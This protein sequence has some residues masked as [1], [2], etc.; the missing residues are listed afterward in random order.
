MKSLYYI[1]PVVEKRYYLSWKNC[2]DILPV[3]EKL[4]NKP[5]F[6][7]PRN[8]RSVI[9]GKLFAI[10]EWTFWD[11]KSIFFCLWGGWLFQKKGVDISAFH[12]HKNI[13]IG[14]LGFALTGN[15]PNSP[16]TV[17]SFSINDYLLL[18]KKLFQKKLFQ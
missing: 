17:W 16:Q 6:Q 11:F 13:Q 7:K 14:E 12:I 9:S 3:V 8:D 5:C 10:T 15:Q 4:K 2:W 18:Q 1:L